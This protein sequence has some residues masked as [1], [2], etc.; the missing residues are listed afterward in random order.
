MDKKLQSNIL[1][2]YLMCSYRQGQATVL[3]A[4]DRLKKL[5]VPTKR[6]EDYFDQMTKSDGHMTKVKQKILVKKKQ[7]ERSQKVKQ[8]REMKKLGKKVQTEVML[9]RAKEKRELMEKIKKYVQY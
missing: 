4:L 3:E 8:I 6:P 1:S 5:D 7:I 9:Q 2:D